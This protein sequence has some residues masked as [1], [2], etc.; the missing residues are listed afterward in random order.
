MHVL[1][2]VISENRHPDRIRASTHTQTRMH[3]HARPDSGGGGAGAAKA[4]TKLAPACHMLTCAGGSAVMPG[5]MPNAPHKA[6]R[7]K[8]GA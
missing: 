1:N 3:G 7:A 2:E 6:T 8:L 4:A 5:P